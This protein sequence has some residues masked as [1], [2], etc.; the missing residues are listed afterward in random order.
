MACLL[1]RKH[2]FN[3]SDEELAERW[4]ENVA[5]QYFSGLEYQTPNAVRCR[6]DWSVPAGVR[7]S[8]GGGIA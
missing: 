2:A 7:G 4:S 5:R 6:A 3:V 8:R 1:C